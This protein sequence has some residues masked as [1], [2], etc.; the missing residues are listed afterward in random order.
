MAGKG[1]CAVHPPAT[2][3]RSHGNARCQRR[4]APAVVGC[5]L[6]PGIVLSLDL[7]M[8]MS[9]VFLKLKTGQGL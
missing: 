2:R 4:R 1:V 3:F 9:H 5:S 8:N 7:S 6:N